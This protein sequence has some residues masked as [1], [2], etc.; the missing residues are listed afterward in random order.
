MKQEVYV[1]D[2]CGEM[3]VPDKVSGHLKKPPR[4]LD[5]CEKCLEELNVIYHRVVLSEVPDRRGGWRKL[6]DFADT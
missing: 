5:F 2:G 4:A 6:G 3:L 1:C